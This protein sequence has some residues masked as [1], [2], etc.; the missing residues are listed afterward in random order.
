MINLSAAHEKWMATVEI[1]WCC[2]LRRGV[3]K[4]ISVRQSQGVKTPG[5]NLVTGANGHLGETW[6]AHWWIAE[7]GCAE[8]SGIPQIACRSFTTI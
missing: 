3:S 4:K 1:N 2:Q 5:V 7:K 8:A 6:Y